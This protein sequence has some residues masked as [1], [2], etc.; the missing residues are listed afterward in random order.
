MIDIRTGKDLKD[1]PVLE[2]PK[3]YTYIMTLKGVFCQ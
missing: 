2:E 1:Y 3:L